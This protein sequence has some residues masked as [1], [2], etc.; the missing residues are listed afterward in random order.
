MRSAS[1]ARTSAARRWAAWSR[2]A[3]D[4]ASAARVSLTLMMTSSGSRRLPGPSL[5]VRNAMISKPEDP[6]SVD[7]VV[8]HS[9]S[10]YKLIGSPSYPAGDAWLR[11]RLT[12]S[13]RRSHRPRGTARQL[14]AIVADGDRSATLAHVRVPTHVI[15][16]PRRHR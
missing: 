1:S 11:E 16:G 5:K 12:M 6:R 3:R 13:V 7:S 2:S 9:V 4:A 8:A 15:H 14:T 10:I